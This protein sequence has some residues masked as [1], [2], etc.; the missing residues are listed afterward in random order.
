MKRL[1]VLLTPV[2]L[3]LLLFG[4]IGCSPDTDSTS[5]PTVN[6]AGDCTAGGISWNQAEHHIG[7]R[8]TVYGPVVDAHYASTS[9]GKPTFL[10][11]GKTYPNPD[12]FTV[13]IWG[14]NRSY[15][16]SPP[17]SYY[18]GKMICVTGLVTEYKGGPQIEARTPSQ[19]Q[20]Y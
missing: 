18:Y 5:I 9:S 3:L 1:A 8:V 11:I 13:V 2:L 20:E 12:R 7:E 6:Q 10:N 15:F 14:S 4:G 19:I 17:E 16:P